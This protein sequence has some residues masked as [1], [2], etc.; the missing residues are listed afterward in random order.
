MEL[1]IAIKKRESVRAFKPKKPS[2]KDVLEAV[3]A[4]L[5]APAA[6]SHFHIKF[7]LIED[8]E[9]IKKISALSDQSWIAESKF[10]AIVTSDDT[11]LENM[12]GERGRV[13]SRQQSGAAIE[14][15]LLKITS[16]GLSACW[17]G[18]YTDERIRSLLKIPQHI[19][20]EAVIPIGYAQQRRDVTKKR[21]KALENVIYWEEWKKEKRP[22]IF[23]EEFPDNS[24]E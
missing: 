2:W 4:A 3:D 13:Y 1:D 6:G 17:V 5:R 15:F 23:K 22:T 24:L 9:K 11:N 14:N 18:A 12:Y 21:K 20:I 16:L 19:Q 10:L 8:K 7:V